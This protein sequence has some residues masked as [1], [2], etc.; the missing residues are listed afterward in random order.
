[1]IPMPSLVDFRSN[2]LINLDLYWPQPAKVSQ[3]LT[4]YKDHVSIINRK[5]FHR[6]LQVHKYLF[7]FYRE[8]NEPKVAFRIKTCAVPDW[9][10]Y[11]LNKIFLKLTHLVGKYVQK[12]IDSK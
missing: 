12:I 1:M 9:M 8:K 11:D 7:T 2:L 10:I 3:E 6:R 5:W 4:F